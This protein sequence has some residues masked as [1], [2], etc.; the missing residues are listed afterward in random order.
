VFDPGASD[1][2]IHEMPVSLETQARKDALGEVF[3]TWRAEVRRH[4][5]EA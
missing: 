2:F 4:Y 1:V 5:Y 3:L